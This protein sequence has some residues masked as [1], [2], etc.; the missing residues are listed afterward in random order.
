MQ[1]NRDLV[2]HRS[3][4]HEDCGLAS[5]YLCGPALQLVHRRIFAVHIVANLGRCHGSAHRRR[6]LRHC[7]TAQIDYSLVRQNRSPF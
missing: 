1:A 6:G 2:P 5:E 4:G 3:C 7:V